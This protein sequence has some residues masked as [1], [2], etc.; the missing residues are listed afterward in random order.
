MNRLIVVCVF[1]LLCGA[2][3]DAQSCQLASTTQVSFGTYSSATL[4]TAGSIGINC[5]S[6]TAYSIALN[7][8]TT[9]GATTTNRMLYCGGCNPKTLGYQIFSNASYTTNWGNNNGVDT[10][11]ATGTGATQNFTTWAQIP[12][13]EAYYSGPNGSNYTDL[14]T[15]TIVCSKCTSIS[16]NNQ[17][18]NVNVQ[19]TAQG[20]GISASDLSF[21]NY[22]GAVL[23]A[24]STVRVGCSRGTNYNVGL[25][26]GTA[27]GAT[28]TT[29]K[30]TGTGTAVLGYKLFS[31]SGRTINWGNTV[32][33]DTVAGHGHG[34]TRSLTVYGQ[35][36]AGQSVQPGSY[37]DTI[38][39]TI[40][41]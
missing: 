3:L 27:T 38:T 40:T 15:V 2:R 30:M 5:T 1:L 18:F 35:I 25:S 34:R 41:Y 32:G 39:A 36:P 20:C 31:N 9:A 37:V 7:A 6:G 23:N 22:T 10:V 29:R 17:S 8:G 11:N 19:G 16:G 28:V 13:L 33:A 14:V 24:T 12:A 26:A 4:R 21:G